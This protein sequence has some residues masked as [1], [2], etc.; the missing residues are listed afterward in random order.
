VIRIGDLE[1]DLVKRRTRVVVDA[2]RG[3]YVVLELRPKAQQ[4]LE[5]M[6]LRPGRCINR[7]ELFEGIWG[8]N[9]PTDFKGVDVVLSGLRQ[10]I[11]AAGGSADSLQT[12][13]GLGYGI[14]ID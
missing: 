2:K 4:L 12:R 13:T 6:A 3:A 1:I 11:R 9:S 8:A 14:N 10:K 5:Y 7:E